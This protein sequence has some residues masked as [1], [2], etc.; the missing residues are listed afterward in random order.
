MK[1]YLK[2]LILGFFHMFKSP[3]I[4]E[5]ADQLLTSTE[6]Q[7]KQNSSLQ[8]FVKSEKHGFDNSYRHWDRKAWRWHEGEDVGL[9]TQV[10]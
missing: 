10:V 6:P 9:R 7:C 8:I 3:S 1:D 2:H 5:P 4:Q